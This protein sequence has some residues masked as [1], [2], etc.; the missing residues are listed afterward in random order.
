MKTL[1]NKG[2]SNMKNT[3]ALVRYFE[4]SVII[5]LV[6][7]QAFEVI[8]K[9]AINQ[10]LENFFTFDSLTQMTLMDFFIQ[11]DQMP[12][13]GNLTGPFLAKLFSNFRDD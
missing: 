9:D 12:W 13:T 2:T 6:S 5:A 3:I 10:V 1:L 4:L 8:A 11:F 7:E